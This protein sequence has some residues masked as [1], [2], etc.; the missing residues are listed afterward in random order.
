MIFNIAKSISF[1]MD[2]LQTPRFLENKGA[3]LT[4]SLRC[5]QKQPLADVFQNQNRCS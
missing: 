3:M 1:I 5:R 2:G 4:V